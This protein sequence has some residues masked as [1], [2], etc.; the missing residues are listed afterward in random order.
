MNP[1]CALRKCL[2]PGHI[3]RAVELVTE[4]VG[5]HGHRRRIEFADAT[6]CLASIPECEHRGAIVWLGLDGNRAGLVQEHIKRLLPAL[7][8]FGQT[9]KLSD[10]EAFDDDD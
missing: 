3:T 7:E 9:G 10:D 8:H 6:G 4:R 2:Q 5:A 1:L